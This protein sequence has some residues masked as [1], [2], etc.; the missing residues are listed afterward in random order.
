MC[1]NAL[2]AGRIANSQLHKD[3][4]DDCQSGSGRQQPRAQERHWMVALTRC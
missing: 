2:T 1:R 4:G 3:S